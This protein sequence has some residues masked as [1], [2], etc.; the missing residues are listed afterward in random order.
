VQSDPPIQ[1]SRIIQTGRQD[2]KRPR[3]LRSSPDQTGDRDRILAARDG[4]L[5]AVA[6]LHQPMG[7]VGK[8]AGTLGRRGL[9][10]QQLLRLG[11]GGQ[12]GAIIQRLVSVAAQQAQEHGSPDRLSGLVHLIQRL[13]KELNSPLGGPGEARHL[14]RPGQQVDPIQ[15]CRSA[16]V[17]HLLPQGQ[18][19]LVVSVGLGK[20]AGA[21]GGQAGLD[22][23]RQCL[24]GFA[25]CLPVDRQLSGTHRRRHASQ[26]RPLGER[27]GVRR[28]EPG[29]FARQQVGV[30]HLL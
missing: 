12:G 24:G 27:L 3:L 26:L 18:G 5:R 2:A 16:R 7:V 25:G 15:P 19:S 8:H 11:I 9:G 29:P 17:G 30:D 14:S 21:F 4:L 13:L 1:L 28:V 23:G 10:S 22:P 20:G 6:G